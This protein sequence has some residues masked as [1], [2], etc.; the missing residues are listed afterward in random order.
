MF[1]RNMQTVP[2]PGRADS[3]PDALWV[4]DRRMPGLT[5]VARYV[6]DLAEP[7]SSNEGPVKLGEVVSNDG[8]LVS[9]GEGAPTFPVEALSVA[10]TL[11]CRRCPDAVREFLNAQTMTQIC[12]LVQ[13]RTAVVP[14]WH[15]PSECFGEPDLT[16]DQ[17]LNDHS[18]TAGGDEDLTYGLDGQ[19]AAGIDEV[20]RHLIRVR[21]ALMQSTPRVRTKCLARIRKHLCWRGC[22]QRSPLCSWSSPRWTS[23]SHPERLRPVFTISL[24]P[25]CL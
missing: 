13:A 22:P 12:G 14:L 9:R 16:G 2:P 21:L 5:A 8:R 20:L 1:H 25:R 7:F 17:N 4:D 18:K 15:R 24:H 11:I 19:I 3:A 10:S 23:Q 6:A